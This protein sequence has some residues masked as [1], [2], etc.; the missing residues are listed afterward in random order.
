MTPLRHKAVWGK[1]AWA[2]TQL[3]GNENPFREKAAW[4]RAF[5]MGQQRRGGHLGHGTC[6]GE[7]TGRHRGE[8]AGGDPGWWAQVETPDSPDVG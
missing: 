7:C 8:A 6:R 5:Q 1:P 2:C 3:E 4:E